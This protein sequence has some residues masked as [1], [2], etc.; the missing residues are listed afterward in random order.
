MRPTAAEELDTGWSNAL[1]FYKN[2]IVFPA[3]AE[4]SNFSA[5]F[6]LKKFL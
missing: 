1:L 2:I 6:R 4:L 3:E 5:D